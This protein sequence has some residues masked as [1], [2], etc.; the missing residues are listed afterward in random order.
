[1]WQLFKLSPPDEHGYCSFGVSNDYTKPAAECAK[2]VIAEVN[3]KM[4]KTMG[5]SFIHISEI[6]YIVESTSD[7]RTYTT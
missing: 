3:D 4:P 6:D 1:M 5:D 2:I 7:N